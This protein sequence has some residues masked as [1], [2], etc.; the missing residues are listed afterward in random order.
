M[1][2]KHIRILAGQGLNTKFTLY[3]NIL[4]QMVI[5]RQRGMPNPSPTVMRGLGVDIN[6]VLL[7]TVIYPINGLPHI[8]NFK[9]SIC[10]HCSSL[11]LNLSSPLFLAGF[12]WERMYNREMGQNSYGMVG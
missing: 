7:P 4:L 3:I 12:A 5:G 9:P 6:L 11:C 2:R 1:E 10:Y 8:V